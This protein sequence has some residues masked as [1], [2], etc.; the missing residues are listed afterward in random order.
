MTID[1][2][3]LILAALLGAIVAWACYLVVQIIKEE[4]RK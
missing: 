1:I 3:I 4:R 2:L